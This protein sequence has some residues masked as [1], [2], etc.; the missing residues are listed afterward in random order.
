MVLSGRAKR[1]SGISL[2]TLT[3]NA[4]LLNKANSDVFRKD[5]KH[6]NNNKKSIDS[7]INGNNILQGPNRRE[8]YYKD[9]VG[10]IIIAAD[11]KFNAEEPKGVVSDKRKVQYLKTSHAENI[12]SENLNKANSSEIYKN[13]NLNNQCSY[14]DKSS[15]KKKTGRPVQS[16]RVKKSRPQR[17]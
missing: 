1:E 14:V 15:F 5:S 7:R 11:K 8:L 2:E 10:N 6:R 16:R 3:T 17:G 9:E 12:Q 4:S 13:I